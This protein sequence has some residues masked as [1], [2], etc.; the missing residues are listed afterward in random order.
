MKA[1]V[2]TVLLTLFAYGVAQAA[3]PR[4]DYQA[5]SR[6]EYVARAA[7]CIS[8]HSRPGAP[9]FSGGDALKTPF[10]KIFAPNITPDST[11]GIGNWSEADFDRALRRGVRKDGAFLYPA[12]PYGSYTQMT[13]AD[14]HALWIYLRGIPAVNHATPDNTLS[15]PFNIRRGIA[16][17]QSLYFKPGRFAPAPDKDKAWNRGA[18]LV[19]ALGHCGAC[20]TPRN[21]AQALQPQFRLTGAQIEG[22]YAPNISSDAL[23]KNATLTVDGLVLFF[24]TGNRADNTNAIGPMRQ[25][26]HDSLRYL[27]DADLHAMATYLK[28]QP[29][30][31]QLQQSI[32]PRLPIERL[33]AGK[34][35]YEDNCSSCHGSDGKGRPQTVPALDGNSAVTARAPYNVIMAV[36]EGFPA[37][38]LWGPMGSFAGTLND[39]QITDVTNYIR[40]AW[41]NRGEPNATPWSVSTWRNNADAPASSEAHSL[42]C[43]TLAQTVIEPALQLSAVSM[44]EAFDEPDKIATLVRRYTAARPKTTVAQTIE[45][46]SA[47]YCRAIATDDLSAGQMS[48]RIADFS[49]QIAVAMTR[50]RPSE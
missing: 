31:P 15:F 10:G 18:Y 29:G 20:H 36:L 27:T 42:L 33:A 16:V 43:P 24:K 11:T 17:W 26:I 5:G 41:S 23:A 49:Q 46:L 50:E 9:S 32:K 3:G 45:A 22:W 39:D 19:D 2:G 4:R 13:D 47:A 48:G 30:T 21:A 40:T 14:A 38:G 7:D 8:C 12:M 34:L 28:D 1:M 37:R 44:R 35:V 25:V 6:G